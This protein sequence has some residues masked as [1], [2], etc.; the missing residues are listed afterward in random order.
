MTKTA[1]PY[2]RTPANTPSLKKN[3]RSNMNNYDFEASRRFG[4]S[5]AYKEYEQKTA[6]YTKDEW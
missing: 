6:N 3:G 2:M 5:D 1:T 4:E